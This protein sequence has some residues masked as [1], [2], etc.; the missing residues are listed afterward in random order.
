MRVTITESGRRFVVA[1]QKGDT[2]VVIGNYPQSQM[3]RA[4]RLSSEVAKLLSCP[5]YI[6]PDQG[7]KR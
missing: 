5:R 1:I 3:E 2:T 6:Y 7:A 4:I